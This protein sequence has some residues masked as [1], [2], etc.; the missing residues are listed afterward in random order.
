MFAIH[1]KTGQKLEF[2]EQGDYVSIMYVLD[3][4]DNRILKKE[5]MGAIQKVV[6][7]LS[8]NLQQILF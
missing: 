8:E 3:E 7:C 6:V 1:I 4:N 2:K 5:A